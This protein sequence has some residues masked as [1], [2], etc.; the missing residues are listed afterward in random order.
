MLQFFTQRQLK[1]VQ[2]RN[3]VI[4]I[5]YTFLGFLFINLCFKL[6]EE[7]SKKQPPE[8][9]GYLPLSV[10]GGGTRIFIKTF[11]S[12]SII[13][14]LA[15]IFQLGMLSKSLINI[16]AISDTTYLVV[17]A[18]TATIHWITRNIRPFI[19]EFRK[20]KYLFFHITALAIPLSCAFTVWWVHTKSDLV[21]QFSPD[22]KGL[23]E[24]AWGSLSA[25]LVVIWYFDFFRSEK[26]KQKISKQKEAEERRRKFIDT[27]FFS[28]YNKFEK[29]LLPI[30]QE[31][32]NSEFEAL[33]SVLIFEN[34]N[35]PKP[36]RIAE[37]IFVRLTKV[38]STVGIAQI[39]STRHLSDED[40]IKILFSKIQNY[41]NQGMSPS[42][43][44]QK[45]NSSPIYSE[46]VNFI[47]NH[48][49]SKNVA[50]NIM[51]LT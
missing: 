15:F 46:E 2:L 11:I 44:F 13:Y 9:I 23:I 17:A 48:L 25:A 26:S 49:S 21:L 14:L 42:E 5:F 50:E 36:I 31:N 19:I 16:H 32:K 38:R 40:S 51:I 1:K 12:R 47:Y 37:N 3:A 7:K 34:A 20:I 45:L 28:I 10:V 29:I 41:S 35:R 30:A 22:P 43:I 33:L 24:N 18:F 6:L 4:I 39:H 27:E 8:F